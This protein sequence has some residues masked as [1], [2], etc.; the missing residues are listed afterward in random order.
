MFA[1]QRREGFYVDLGSIFDLADLRPFSSDHLLPPHMNLPGVD[2]L[3]NSNVHSI[4]LQI[5]ITELSE[6]GK[7]PSSPTGKAA[8]IGVWTTAGR[9]KSSIRESNGTT[10]LAG[11]Y[12]QVS[13]WAILVINEVIIPMAHKDGWNA[14]SPAMDSQYAAHYAHPILQTYLVDLYPG[15]F[16]NLSK[17]KKARVDLE[18]ILLTGFRPAWCRSRTR[19]TPARRRQT[20]CD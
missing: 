13:R 15:V 7:A 17:Y 10:S 12:V 20:C 2:A 1:G 6:T 11:P 4:A 8:V 19:P 14:T 18:A 16:P 5:P 9:R 3:A